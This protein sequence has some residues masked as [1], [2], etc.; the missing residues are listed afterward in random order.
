MD[1]SIVITK[2]VFPLNTVDGLRPQSVTFRTLSMESAKFVCVRDPQADGSSSL[3]VVDTEAGISERHNIKTAE[4]AI[5]N[6]SSKILALRIGMQMQVFNLDTQESV[7]KHA[8]DEEVVFW[9][10]LD[11]ST[12]AVVTGSA[13][14]H[15]ELKKD[16][17]PPKKVFDRKV[18]LVALRILNY[19]VDPSGMW[20]LLSGC[21]P[22]AN[23]LEGKSELYSKERSASLVMDGFAGVFC[24][25]PTP[26]DPNPNNCIL[27][28][29]STTNLVVR[30]L[31]VATKMDRTKMLNLSVPITLGGGNDFPVVAHVTPHNLLMLVSSQGTLL[32]RDVV[33]GD[34]VY[35]DKVSSN[36]VFAGVPHKSGGVQC[37]NNNGSVFTVALDNFTIVPYIKNTV[38]NIDLSLR[39]ASAANL[40]GVDDL[41]RAQFADLLRKEDI[42]GA[43]D[44]CIRAPNGMLRNAQVLRQLKALTI[45]PPPISMYFKEVMKVGKLNEVESVELARVV[46]TKQQ[47]ADYI[48]KEMEEG[49]FTLSSD[50][51]EIIE[52]F[53]MDL[54]LQV[55][56]KSE[57]HP[58]VLKICFARG[59]VQKAIVYCKKVD[60]K[61][62]WRAEATRFIQSNPDQ[63][64]EFALAIH[65]NMDPPVLD[66]IEVVDMFVSQ[67]QIRNAT[68]YLM[69]VLE[70]FSG[71]NTGALQTKLFE[72]NIKHSPPNVAEK[73]FARNQYSNYDG[74]RLAPLCEQAGL[75]Q[76]AVECYIK[77]QYQNADLD[78]LSS[79]RRCLKKAESFNGEWLI[80]F[81]GKLNQNDC[82]LC[83]SDLL[84]HYQQHFNVI[85]QVS[86]KYSEFLGPVSLIEMFLDKNLYDMI[87]AY[88]VSIVPHTRDP[89]VHFRYI[90]AALET[91]NMDEVERMTKDS[92]CY[93]GERVK[94]LIKGKKLANLWPFINV[95]DRHDYIG[96]M[97]HFLMDTDNKHFIEEYVQRRN[98]SKTP[99]VVG[100]LLDCNGDEKFIK[101]VLNAAGTM[102][103][104]AELVEEVESRG[105]LH[106]ILPWLEA[107]KA[108]K[109]TDPALYNALGKIYV[110]TDNHPEEFL[111]TN[112]YYDPI[113]LGKYCEN[114]NTTLA[115]VAYKKAKKDD[116]VLALT[117]QN[118]MWKELARYLVNR[119]DPQLWN[120][121]LSI[122][123]Q[124]KRTHLVEAVQQ[125]ALP[126]SKVVEEVT[127][128][129]TAFLNANM[130]TELTSILDQI[131]LHGEFRNNKALEDLLIIS[132][133]KSRPD[134]V[135]EYVNNLSNYSAENMAEVA[136]KAKLYEVAFAIYDK[137]GMHKMAA[138]M[139]LENLN[140]L[141]RGRA[142]AAKCDNNQVWTV[143]AVRLLKENEVHEAIEGL[144]R[145]KNPDYVSEVSDAC[146][147]VNQFGDLIKYLMMARVESKNK[148][149]KIDTYLVLTYA[150]TGRLTELEDFLKTSRG[151]QLLSVADKCF[152]DGLYDSA[153]VLYQVASNFQKLAITL[154]KLGN[155]QEAVA[156]ADKAKNITTWK[157]VNQA[158]LEAEEMDLARTCAVPVVL[159][160]GELQAIIDLYES[161]GYWEELAAV[162][163]I[164][165]S[166]SGAHMGIYTELGI[167][168]ARYSPVKLL[169]HVNLYSKK[170]NIHKMITI[171]EEYHH[172]HVLRVLYVNN[173]DWLA[174][175]NA[176]MAHAADC[177][178]HEVFKETVSH[179]GS[180]DVIY[181]ALPFYIECH[182]ELLAN[183]LTS[184]AKKV[185][186]DRVISKVS[187][188]APIYII[189]PFL[190]AIQDRN[191]KRINEVLNDLYVEEENFAALRKSADQY[192]NFDSAKLS[193]RLEK[194]DMFEFRKIALALHRRNKRFAHA[195]EVAKENRLYREAI[196]T[197]A[198]SND[199]D[200]VKSLLQF[201][202]D[203]KLEECFAAC[204]FT[205]YDLVPPHVAMEMSWK[206]G[207]KDSAMPFFIQTMHQMSTRMARLESALEEAQK[208]PN[209]HSAQAR[210]TFMIQD[211]R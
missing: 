74:M 132:A 186:P 89:E 4:A 42:A 40:G 69:K 165:A 194:L 148:N 78:N 68:H 205:C 93:D 6:P 201:F 184:V 11:A 7:M 64:V 172:W 88:L 51:G 47:S 17:G 156:A 128:T 146:E 49:K 190:E 71:P 20:C 176:M 94:N 87:Y 60:Y 143:L 158:C 85:V 152:D 140:D 43:I 52:P 5:M 82:R 67:Q 169:D 171:C 19:K 210:E 15:W 61:P 45:S 81:F 174:A 30:E 101:E 195:V 179:L 90:E 95:C 187:A 13:V 41:F 18:E 2:E 198:E 161:S 137:H 122:D 204:L 208:G 29:A 159:R 177:W 119:Q 182:P 193:Q 92:P 191:V 24:S 127:A 136:S 23:G 151:V 138:Q 91:G 178:D 163:K 153:K 154:V 58:K 25:M 48:K 32:I 164:A 188:V 112:T 175:A 123:D 31:P 141:P 103:P 130:N 113:E 142:Y 33:T 72:I 104:V 185:D 34:A 116:Q 3:V 155:I 118:G 147:R 26:L 209:G 44:V 70:E 53:D 21:Q 202:V 63:A 160:A 97:V 117:I 8:S 79:I 173:G 96:E 27:C 157:I 167:L 111:L 36:T 110:D 56:L 12:I 9:K 46:T 107:R 162:L 38:G 150:K 75:F 65:K 120:R 50:L 183:Y 108:E 76:R 80:D 144:I 84:E 207:F 192:N 135:M 28:L 129:V 1:R 125:T 197:T 55:Y 126:E 124:R 114:R 206:A 57:A 83:L 100:A 37:V 180:S 145:A 133:V 105:R 106:I 98:P 66:P 121:V 211:R 131:V 166:Q 99:Q 170:M 86:I 139:L 16:G 189:R 203:E 14:F 102:C 73:L 115:F 10:W 35:Q 200:V 77:A 62:D 54:A 39:V 22:G 134:K 199:Q 196:E 59:D 168:Y 181:A 149:P 109:K